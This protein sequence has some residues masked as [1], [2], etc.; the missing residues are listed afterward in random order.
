M[1]VENASDKWTAV[2]EGGASAPSIAIAQ[3]AAGAAKGFAIDA[4]GSASTAGAAASTATAQ[5]GIAATIKNDILAI[6]GIKGLATTKSEANAALAAGN[7]ANGTLV[8]VKADETKSGASWDYQVS[9]SAFIDKGPAITNGK[10]TVPRNVTPATSGSTTIFEVIPDEPLTNSAGG[11]DAVVSAMRQTTNY[12][13]QGPTGHAN[14]YNSVIGF[15]HNINSAF[16]PLN[17]AQIAASSRIE[18]KFAQGAPG[19]FFGA[20][21]HCASLL[22]VGGGE[23]R[24]ITAFIAHDKTKWHVSPDGSSVGFAAYSHIWRDGRNAPRIQ[25]EFSDTTAKM[26]FTKGDQP[27]SF[28]PQIYFE[29]NNRAPLFLINAAHNAYVEAF[30]LTAGDRMFFGNPETRQISG[31]AGALGFGTVASET[32]YLSPTAGTTG[33]VVT[34][35]DVTGDYTPEWWSG[36]VSGRGVF[37]KH[38]TTSGGKFGQTWMSNNGDM[39][40]S[41]EDTSVGGNPGFSIRQVAGAGTLVFDDGWRGEA[42]SKTMLTLV[43]TTGQAQFSYAPK[44]PSSVVGSL[45][46]AATAG[47]GSIQYVTDLNATTAGSVAAGGGSNKGMVV[48]SGAD[49]RIVAAW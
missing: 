27:G 46:A 7:Y 16:G 2:F 5:A 13:T 32:Q 43:R 29:D 39:F 23:L 4:S 8:R 34:W 48:C 1:P 19:S 41:F 47:A 37:L 24:A 28:A 25:Y 30:K 6:S 35:Q 18:F 40:I 10:I 31:S 15:G 3:A 42:G 44:L 9:G 20:E 21:Y 11:N 17:T 45:P 38:N 33:Q 49:W 36:G 14:Y 12:W 26:V 22:P